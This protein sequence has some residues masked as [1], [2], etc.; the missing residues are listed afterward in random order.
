M[1]LTATS[2]SCLGDG[3]IVDAVEQAV[4]LVD[5]AVPAMRSALLHTAAVMQNERGAPTGAVVDEPVASG[6]HQS[7]RRDGSNLRH[8]VEE[9]IGCSSAWA[10]LGVIW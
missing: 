8:V 1:R 3:L 7:A 9:R 5:G 4:V 2:A 6:V 10:E